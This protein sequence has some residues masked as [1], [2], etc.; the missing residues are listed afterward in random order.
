MMLT[1]YVEEF[2]E[3]KQQVEN[4]GVAIEELQRVLSEMLELNRVTNVRDDDAP[5][6]L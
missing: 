1:K 6:P 2:K 5:T 3:L 4:Q